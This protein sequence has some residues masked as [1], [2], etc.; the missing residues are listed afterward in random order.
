VGRGAEGGWEIFYNG[1]DNSE[2]DDYDK[3]TLE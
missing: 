3:I 1:E 2:G